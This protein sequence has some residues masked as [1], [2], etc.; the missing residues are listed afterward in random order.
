MDSGLDL[1]K[2]SEAYK[3]ARFDAEYS[4][5]GGRRISGLQAV[6]DNAQPVGTAQSETPT[7]G[8]GSRLVN[9]K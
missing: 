4:R 7:G 8:F 1:G 9:L 2:K 3:A 5:I 6:I